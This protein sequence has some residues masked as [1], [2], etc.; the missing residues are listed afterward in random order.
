MWMPLWI[1]L[2]EK[3]HVPGEIYQR[4]ELSA[5]AAFF[6]DFILDFARAFLPG[7]LVFCFVF[8]CLLIHGSNN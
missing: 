5:R 6:V 7:R 1:C 8:V 4:R 3:A 2:Q